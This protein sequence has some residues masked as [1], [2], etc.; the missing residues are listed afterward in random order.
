M[1]GN[2]C[3]ILHPVRR[4]MSAVWKN[5]TPGMGVLVMAVTVGGVFPV[6][7]VLALLSSFIGFPALLPLGLAALLG[8]LVGLYGWILGHT[9]ALME[10]RKEK[11]IGTL[12]E[13][14]T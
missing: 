9:A 4:D 5:N 7:L 1:G 6:Y 14:L 2:L 12:Q 13:K 11:L 3:S 8:V 10:N